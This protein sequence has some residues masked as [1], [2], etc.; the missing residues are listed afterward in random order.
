[1]IV[2]IPLRYDRMT[3]LVAVSDDRGSL[4]RKRDPD[5]ARA[6]FFIKML[7]LIMRIHIQNK[8]RDHEKNILSSKKKKDSI[9]GLMVNGMMRTLG[10]R[11]VIVSPG[12]IRLT[13]PS[14]SVRKIFS[15]FGLEEPEQ[16]RSSC[17][18]VAIQTRRFR[19][20]RNIELLTVI[21][22]DVHDEGVLGALC[23][24]GTGAPME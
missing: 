11:I 16:G 14:K 9:C 4:S 23:Y 7:A 1:M 6:R 24:I 2:S 15:L 3:A 5:R 19:H 13:P 21:D 10:T 12:Y 20:M 18:D 8:I 17:H 22:G